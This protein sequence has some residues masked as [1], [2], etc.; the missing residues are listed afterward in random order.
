MKVIFNYTVFLSIFLSS[1]AFS[2]ENQKQLNSETTPLL[3]HQEIIDENPLQKEKITVL[4]IKASAG[5]ESSKITLIRLL[6]KGSL[7]TGTPFL[8]HYKESNF[9]KNK[10]TNWEEYARNLNSKKDKDLDLSDYLLSSKGYVFIYDLFIDALKHSDTTQLAN[11]RNIFWKSIESE[12]FAT[13]LKSAYE[14]VSTDPKF[15]KINRILDLIDSIIDNKSGFDG[16]PI[17]I[18]YEEKKPESCIIL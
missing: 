6:T 10:I 9:L 18:P 4:N 3:S 14:G 8:T 16:N 1:Y 5:D 7:P 13:A 12:F 15:K 11:F 2:M 17:L